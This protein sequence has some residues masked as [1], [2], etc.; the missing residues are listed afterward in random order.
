MLKP[1]TSLRF[2]F[3]YMVFSGHLGGLFLSYNE[4][5][6]TDTYASYLSMSEGYL[7]VS[8]FFILSGF[9]LS[10]KYKD[11]FLQKKI[12]F[13]K[14]ILARIF[15][16]Y[17]LHILT[18]GVAFLLSYYGRL[19]D[20][21]FWLKSVANTLLV[22]SF[23][24]AKEYFFS[25]NGVSWSISNEMF[26]YTLFPLLLLAVALLRKYILL[27]LLI[28]ILIIA[29][30]PST[31]ANHWVYYINPL[32]RVF[33]FILGILLFDMY[34]RYKEHAWIQK[35]ATLL[36][37][38]S[39]AF[40][41]MCYI[42]RSGVSQ[43]FRWSIYYWL[44]MAFLIFIFSFQRGIISHILSKKTLIW[45]GEISFAFYM[46]HQLVIQV[47][48]I[49]N[50]KFRLFE[51]GYL[52][53]AVAFIISVLGSGILYRYFEKPLNIYLRKKYIRK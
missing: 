50:Y 34:T 2:V 43:D 44:P 40:F 8:F 31:D 6:L 48:W 21:T 35:N 53:I 49:V 47:L 12:P 46:I 45:L 1:L 51:N 26:F 13:K 30:V 28:P 29:F 3:A 10:F 38:I 22:Q 14:F 16:I 24:P 11:A 17:P 33:D 39:I 20:I 7:G 27:V 41:S 15:R 23:I 5:F 42:F 4:D 25:F 32:F 36:E 19:G 9:I 37:V 18:F 52:L